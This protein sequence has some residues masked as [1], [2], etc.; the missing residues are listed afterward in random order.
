MNGVL[1]Y[2]KKHKICKKLLSLLLCL[3]TVVCFGG[4]LEPVNAVPGVDDAILFF[5]GAFLVCCGM[6]FTSTSAISTAAQ[7]FYD[8]S[9]ADVQDIIDYNAHQVEVD[10]ALGNGFIAVIKSEW[11]ALID[12]FVRQFPQYC[13]IDLDYSNIVKNQL[14]EDTFFKTLAAGTV[15]NISNP[16]KRDT[17]I[18]IQTS[19]YTALSFY[20]M[21]T[22]RKVYGSKLY[23]QITQH[24]SNFQIENNT[25][26][27]VLSVPALDLSEIL[28]IGYNNFDTSIDCPLFYLSNYSDVLIKGVQVG[29]IGSYSLLLYKNEICQA[30]Y[31]SAS[32]SYTLTTSGGNVISQWL[33]DDVISSN[34]NLINCDDLTICKQDLTRLL[35]GEDVFSVGV[36]AAHLPGIDSFPSTADDIT[37]VGTYPDSIGISV[38]QDL[39]DTIS[40]TAEDIRTVDKDKTDTKDDTKEEPDTKP[41]KPSIPSLSLP[42]ILFKEKFPFCLPW[43]VYNV[44]ANLVAEP[45][46]PV[47]SIP[48]KF[49]R[50]GIDYEFTIDLSEF[51]DIAKISRFFSS[52]A[53]VIF[54][55]LASR[56]LIGAE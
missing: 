17:N 48:F 26:F 4:V 43:D 50:L 15:V 14:T 20:G 35:L 22:L 53:F 8:S 39:T 21:D 24:S 19:A 25:Q 28:L 56:K 32:Q 3:L 49:E 41:N 40:K 29:A 18:F 7:N 30:S 16:W 55:I 10:S 23:N 9:P 27:A 51:E 37:D 42:E 33:A 52:I 12:E 36:D 2:L 34:D 44:F 54:L 31:D 38:P 45:E 13:N 6:T 5:L 46:A 11:K 47:F 1:K